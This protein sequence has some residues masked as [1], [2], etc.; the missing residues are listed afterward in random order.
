[1][2]KGAK[3]YI[4]N[5]NEGPAKGIRGAAPY[6]ELHI[7][8]V[9]LLPSDES[10]VESRRAVNLIRSFHFKNAGV[11]TSFLPVMASNMF[12]VGTT[13]MAQALHKHQMLVAMEKHVK[14]NDV[15]QFLRTHEGNTAIPTVG[16]AEADGRNLRAIFEAAGKYRPNMIIIDVPNGHM[17]KELDTIELYRR[18]Y[19][20]VVIMAGNVATGTMARKIIQAGADVVKVG[21]GPGSACTTKMVAGAHRPQG[22]AI[23]E[24]A[25]AVHSLGAYIIGD[26]GVKTAGDVAIAMALGADIVM[27][28]GAFGAHDESGQ[29]IYMDEK[30]Q[31]WQEFMGSSSAAYM[32][33]TQGEVAHYRAPEGELQWILHKGSILAPGAILQEIMGG[34]RSAFSYAGASNIVEFSTMARRTYE[35]KDGGL[36]LVKADM[37]GSSG[38]KVTPF[39]IV[40]GRANPITGMQPRLELIAA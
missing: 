28:G 31:E 22:G 20:G 8:Q 32:L 34:M 13:T 23:R 3:A 1:M 30:G 9:R 21:I 7:Q 24:C 10:E 17:R 12:G 18:E 19:P 11:S 33:R 40:K 29:P 15:A 6:E 26:G 16:F 36:L 4:F 38:S 27:I 37:G 39:R 35:G 5:P 14:P 2:S 25:E